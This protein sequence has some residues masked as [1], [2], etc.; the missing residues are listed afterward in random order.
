MSLSVQQI[1]LGDKIENYKA[2]RHVA[3]T[4][5]GR[6]KCKFL[7]EISGRQRTCRDIGVHGTAIPQGTSNETGGS[8]RTDLICITVETSVKIL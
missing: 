5:W 3:D 4:D 8:G 7:T 2:V 1:L 6:N